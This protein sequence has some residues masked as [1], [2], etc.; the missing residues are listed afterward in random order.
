MRIIFTLLLLQLSVFAAYNPFFKDPEADKNRVIIKAPKTIKA[1]TPAPK[2]KSISMT[3]FGFVSSL[4][5][6]FALV[7]FSGKNI[8]IRQN[9][10]LYNNEEIFK[11]GEITS[12]YIL[13]KDRQGRAQTVYFSSGKK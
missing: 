2:R 6:E 11:V 5:G 7:S 8:V 9:D 4:T 1:Y 12:N 3:Y 13:L 10:S